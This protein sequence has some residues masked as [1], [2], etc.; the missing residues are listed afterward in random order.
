M[1]TH[2]HTHTH[3]QIDHQN[4]LQTLIDYPEIKSHC[5]LRAT[6]MQLWYLCLVDSLH[7]KCLL[8]LLFCDSFN[9]TIDVAIIY[10][11]LLPLNYFHWNIRKYINLKRRLKICLFCRPPGIHL[12]SPIYFPFALS[13][14]SSILYKY[15]ISSTSRLV[16]TVG[17]YRKERRKRKVSSGFE[18]KLCV[19]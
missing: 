5:L 2:P 8:W 10:L 14:A 7:N 13:S 12:L 16:L 19:S 15:S 1:H 17:T 6:K 3:T 18:F 4:C 11:S 9:L